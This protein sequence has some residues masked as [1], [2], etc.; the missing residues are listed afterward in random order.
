M[1]DDII[2]AFTDE[3]GTRGEAVEVTPMPAERA[4]NEDSPRV[5][6]SLLLQ[7]IGITD[8]DKT[9]FVMD[10][11]GFDAAEDLYRTDVEAWTN[12]NVTY[13]GNLKPKDI[14]LLAGLYT[15]YRTFSYLKKSDEMFDPFM[16][17]R[18]VNQRDYLLIIMEL[19]APKAES[20]RSDDREL[21]RSILSHISKLSESF[22]SES[23]ARPEEKPRIKMDLSL[24]PKI[25]GKNWT[26][27][28]AAFTSIASA[29]GLDSALFGLPDD[30]SDAVI[31]N[32]RSNC[33]LMYSALMLATNSGDDAWIVKRH[34]RNDSEA[35]SLESDMQMAR[36]VRKH[37]HPVPTGDEYYPRH[38][39]QR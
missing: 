3:G 13:N 5:D 21:N 27:T 19:R 2:D 14:N 33:K 6:A 32:H 9:R 1:F 30:A 34:D 24:Y 28:K 15:W 4:R 8:P 18:L 25:P 35:R 31:L 17:H 26:I 10:T 7:K 12:L 36:G 37:Q 22:R 11:L 16:K 23:Q 38:Q 39:V 20:P 29:H